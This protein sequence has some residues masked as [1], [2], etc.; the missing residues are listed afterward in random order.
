MVD[1]NAVDVFSVV[2]ANVVPVVGL[3]NLTNAEAVRSPLLGVGNWLA[4]RI[5][6]RAANL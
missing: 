5:M 6:L 1:I 2:V 4:Y 3:L